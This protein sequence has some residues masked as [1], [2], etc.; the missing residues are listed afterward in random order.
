[1]RDVV[2]AFLA[3][4]QAVP[5]GIGTALFL[6]EMAPGWIRT[7]F[8]EGLDETARVRRRVPFGR[9]MTARSCTNGIVRHTRHGF[10]YP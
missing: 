9:P 3:L 10:W 6:S 8:A 7:S 1:M 2:A 4:L 5:L